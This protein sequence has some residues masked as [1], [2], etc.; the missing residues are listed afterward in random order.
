MQIQKITEEGKQAARTTLL[1]DHNSLAHKT[2]ENTCRAVEIAM[3]ALDGNHSPQNR[4]A[5][6]KA[7]QEAGL[8]IDDLAEEVISAIN[9]CHQSIM[10]KQ[11]WE[12]TPVNTKGKGMHAPRK[13][14]GEMQK[15][16]T[17]KKCHPNSNDTRD[18]GQS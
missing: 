10:E 1:A 2:R 12:R 6:Q 11:I 13:L 5:A 17:S 9:T 18:P 14:S 15:S 7:L 3:Q 4:V 16:A 8:T